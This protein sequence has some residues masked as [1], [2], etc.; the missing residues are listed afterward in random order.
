MGVFEDWARSVVGDTLYEA[1]EFIYE[2]GK[3]KKKLSTKTSD[4]LNPELDRQ[5]SPYTSRMTGGGKYYGGT[6]AT[7]NA[8][9]DIT[10][11]G[12]SSGVLADANTFFSLA[13]RDMLKKEKSVKSTL[14]S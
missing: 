14:D 9:Y 2:V 4:A 13:L 5:G 1:G 7:K 6:G 8:F 11:K 12:G 3:T 10:G